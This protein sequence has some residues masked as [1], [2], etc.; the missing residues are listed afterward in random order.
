MDKSGPVGNVK[1]PRQEGIGRDIMALSDVIN[2]RI[3][4][5]VSRR[6]IRNSLRI[7]LLVVSPRRR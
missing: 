2:E 5:V 4:V 6:V 3:F 7:L 1:P